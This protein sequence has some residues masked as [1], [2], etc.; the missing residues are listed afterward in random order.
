[1]L[2]SR[3][4]VINHVGNTFVD[5]VLVSKPGVHLGN[6]LIDSLRSSYFLNDLGLEGVRNIIFRDFELRALD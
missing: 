4:G 6:E 1:M 3:I 5:N 2:I